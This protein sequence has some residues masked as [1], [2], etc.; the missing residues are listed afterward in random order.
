[1][2]LA[3]VPGLR[4]VSTIVAG[5]GCAPFWGR[6][7]LARYSA[8]GYTAP[9]ARVH[10]R[11]LR[12]GNNTFVGDRT[13]IYLD[14]D[15]GPVELG[16]RVHINEDTWLITGAGG[17]IAIGR[18]THVQGRCNLHAYVSGIRLGSDVQV[19]PACAFYPYDH[20]IKPGQAMRNQPAT[21]K[22]DIV[23]GNDVWLGHG[24]IVLAGVTI[25]DGAVV[26]A[27]SIVTHDVPAETI[28]AGVP[29]RALR[30]RG[31]R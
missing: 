21:S 10:H 2:G 1:M 4:R 20:G 29:A 30:R 13:T 18:D 15:G 22:G 3:S 23:V 27:G 6:H 25:G 19:G 8:A 17:W 31:D 7:R 12:R 16:D 14:V 24:V 11:R 5:W 9:S 26:A 28:A